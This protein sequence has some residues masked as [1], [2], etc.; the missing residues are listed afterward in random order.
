MML[1]P[2]VLAFR[3]AA[4][5]VDQGLS[6]PPGAH[7]RYRQALLPY[8]ECTAEHTPENMRRHMMRA[9][10]DHGVPLGVIA[11]GFKATQPELEYV[12]ERPPI[13]AEPIDEIERLQRM[14]YGQYLRTPHWRKVRD[15]AL[16]RAQGRCALCNATDRLQVHH[17]T[18]ERRGCERPADVVVLCDDCHGRHHGHLRVA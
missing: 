15:E 17:R 4:Y 7:E 9:L 1:D 12:S 13:E 5:D 16:N 14:P 6:A 10:F 18:Y 11:V 2:R 8:V 3:A